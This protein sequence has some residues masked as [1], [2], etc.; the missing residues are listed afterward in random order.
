[1]ESIILS[2]LQ[3]LAV[4]YIAQSRNRKRIWAWT[5]FGLFIPII[6]LIAVLCVDK[7]KVCP[8][9]AESIKDEA[10]V[11]KHCGREVE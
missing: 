4:T 7:L 9:C 10:K 3:C 1:M 6:P 5:I 8:N 2:I 11:C